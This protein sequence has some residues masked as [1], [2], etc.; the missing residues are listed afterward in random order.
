MRFG[1]GWG[2]AVSG[3][4][5][6]DLRGAGGAR[7]RQP[8]APAA[9]ARWTS[10]PPTNVLST[11]PRSVFPAHGEF[12]ERER[13]EENVVVREVEKRTTSAGAPSAS[14]PYG[15]PKRRAGA[16]DI[17]STSRESE[18]SLG[19]TRPSRRTE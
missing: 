4:A 2:N 12:A 19:A 17:A 8:A 10:R 14:V 15:R 13:N 11:R 16:V 6:S 5:T 9:P 18:T 3:T 7:R 1:G